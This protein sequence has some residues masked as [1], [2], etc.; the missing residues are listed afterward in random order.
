MAQVLNELGADHIL[1]IHGDECLDEISI[2]GP[3]LVV[4]LLD[5]TITEK[6]LYPKDFGLTPNGK[7]PNSRRL[8]GRK[9]KIDS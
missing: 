6:R 5:G 3:T 1:I 9:C 4:E 7:K 2:D 8:A